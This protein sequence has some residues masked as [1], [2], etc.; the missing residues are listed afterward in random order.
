[1]WRKEFV[2]QVM[3]SP[4]IFPGVPEG[5]NE[6]EV[7]GL[8]DIGI[9]YVR[10]VARILGLIYGTPMA[11][12]L[13]DARGRSA[14]I[15]SEQP[16]EATIR[17]LSRLGLFRELGFD[18]GNVSPSDV[19]TMLDDVLPP[20]L[21]EPLYVNSCEHAHSVC[22]QVAPECSRC[23]VRNFC[24]KFRR[25]EEQ[26]LDQSGAPTVIDLFC[27]AGGSSDGFARAGFHPVL[28]LD[29]NE[30]AL[31]SYWLNHPGVP[32]ERILCRDIWGVSPDEIRAHLGDRELDVLIGSPPCQGFSHVGSR[33]KQGK[34]G[35]KLSEDRRNYLFHAMVDLAVALRP[36]LFLMENVPGM[37][38]ARSNDSSF[39]ELA[40][41]R[42]EE[43]GGYRTEVWR[44]NAAAFGVPQDRV[45][46]FLAASRLE[47]MPVRP[48]GEYQVLQGQEFNPVFEEPLP[49]ITIGDAIFDLPPLN[50]DS[51]ALM[52]FRASH[53]GMAD[54]RCRRYLKKFGIAREGAI[55]Y[56]HWS[57]YNNE[58]DLELY[59]LL[60]Q[61]EDSV[62]MIEKYGRADLMRY[63]KDVFDDKYARLREDK[64][65]K[66]IVAHLA[67][68]GN[69]YV[70]P[71]E[72]RS[73]SLREAARLQSFHD[74]FVFCGSPSDQWVQVGNAVPPIL[75][76]AIARN[77]MRTLKRLKKS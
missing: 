8:V 65:S 30:A 76:E 61:G 17:V 35:Y 66:T 74:R 13:G 21:R 69:G 42:L 11:T 34:T 20:V 9:S 51:G 15:S 64:P 46:Y 16:S 23:E 5:A 41:R 26:R 71:T 27:G 73:I 50:A 12:S 7:R 6:V 45:R 10:E 63:R 67:K 77:F 38:S 29:L 44:L 58:R 1:M 48:H 70:H 37:Q 54:K 53:A 31:R 47:L 55:L 32:E 60:Q 22:H 4:E 59:G 43:E 72:V 49:P 18:L 2:R 36:G 75:A 56:Q 24:G 33:S 39:L 68:D 3:A 40:A 62:H 57:R 25:D 52:D 14:G 28:S 19:G